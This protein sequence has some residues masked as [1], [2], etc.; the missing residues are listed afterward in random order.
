MLVVIDFYE[1]DFTVK[2]EWLDK[3]KK[4]E[5]GRFIVG[6][7]YEGTDIIMKSLQKDFYEVTKHTMENGVTVIN[8]FCSD[9]KHAT[10]ATLWVQEIR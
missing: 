1:T 8:A 10:S 2:N 5:S 4:Y 6:E 9:D 7:K 3:P